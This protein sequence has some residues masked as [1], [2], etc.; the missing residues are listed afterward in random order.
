[1]KR[2]AQPVPLPIRAALAAD[3]LR[4]LYEIFRDE[5]LCAWFATPHRVAIN[6]RIYWETA[7]NY[8]PGGAIFERGLLEWERRAFT[9]PPFPRAG[10]VLLGGAG[11]GRE[12]LALC[13]MGFD[14]VAFEPSG[15]CAGARQVAASFPKSA[16]VQASYED[17]IDAAERR[18]GPLAAHV[19][20]VSIDAVVFGWT[21]FGD[22]FAASDRSGLLHATHA[23]APMAPLLLSFLTGDAETG[24]LDRIRPLLRRIY[25]WLGAPSTRSR[26]DA[27]CPPAGFTHFLSKNELEDLA[28][29]A[30]YRMLYYRDW[31]ANCP[32][33]MLLPEEHSA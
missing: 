16:A 18:T 3:R 9:E 4:R 5:T 30:G 8:L 29:A 28:R 10:R 22:V 6:Q 33:A 19:L 21:S 17:L 27:F 12:L 2:T 15:L 20:G 23:I 1:V 32:Y 7:D 26:G 14:V 25:A 13:K 31:G 24:R 11:G